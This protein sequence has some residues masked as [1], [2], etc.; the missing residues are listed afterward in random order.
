MTRTARNPI[1]RG[2]LVTRLDTPPLHVIKPRCAMCST[3]VNP[4]ETRRIRT[5]AS[6]YL[7]V[8]AKCADTRPTLPA[9]TTSP[10][11]IDMPKTKTKTTKAAPRP[12]PHTLAGRL[13]EFFE[14]NTDESL[15]VTDIHIK[16]DVPTNHIPDMLTHSVRNKWL[17]ATKHGTYSA[18]QLLLDKLHNDSTGADADDAAAQHRE[19]ESASKTREED[20]APESAARPSTPMATRRGRKPRHILDLS[21]IGIEDDVHPGRQASRRGASCWDPLLVRLQKDYQATTPISREH[22]GAL[23]KAAIGYNKRHGTK[24]VVR[25]TEDGEHFRIHRMPATAAVAVQKAA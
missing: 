17:A 14:R 20:A 2:Q 22:Q 21:T 25:I 7:L 10:Q 12:A 24:L 4:S 15:S 16:Y 6:S 18:G 19:P 5:S 13:I 9:R 3:R 11:E 23:Q 8:C 1:E